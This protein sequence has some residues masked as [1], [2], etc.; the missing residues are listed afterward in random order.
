LLKTPDIKVLEALANLEHNGNFNVILG[1]IK[2]SKDD[3]TKELGVATD[4]KL[5][6][7]Q[8]AFG[9]LDGLHNHASDARTALAKLSP[10]S[11]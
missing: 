2:E 8:G 11:K 10:R 1:W 3:A 4:V 7:A 9:V 6:R 5:Y